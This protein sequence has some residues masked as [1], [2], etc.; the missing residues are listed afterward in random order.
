ME[1]CFSLE[2]IYLTPLLS[3]DPYNLQYKGDRGSA[4]ANEVTANGR[5]GGNSTD[6]AY[7]GIHSTI[8]YKTPAEFYSGME[9]NDPADTSTGGLWVLDPSR[10]P[11]RGS[12]SGVRIKMQ[13]IPGVGIVHQRYLIMPIHGEGN[14]IYKE[15]EALKDIVLEPEKFAYM[16]RENNTNTVGKGLAL[17]MKPAKAEFGK[18]E[19]FVYLTGEEVELLYHGGTVPKLSEMENGHQHDLI[20]QC[21]TNKGDPFIRY[22]TCDKIT[23]CFD[24]HKKPLIVV[25]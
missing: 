7:D 14:T 15:L 5:N 25:E 2:I 13:T 11:R 21:I 16:L 10:T 18:H 23:Y 20:L 19:H 22:N 24:G 17:K 1:L 12:T 6:K 4:L 9:P 8:Y 3:W